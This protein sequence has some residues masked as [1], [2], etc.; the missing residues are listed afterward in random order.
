MTLNLSFL[1]LAL[2]SIHAWGYCNDRNESCAGWA[3]AG[4]CEGKDWVKAM[5][6]HSCAACPHTCRDSESMCLGWAD[7]GECT[8]NVDY[9]YKHCGASCGVCKTRCYDKDPACGDWARQGECARNDGL[10]TILS[11]IHI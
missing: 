6:P 11:L 9:M 4:E 7:A 10:L 1:L 5:C 8:N 2:P 3:A